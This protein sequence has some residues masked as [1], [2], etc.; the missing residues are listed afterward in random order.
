LIGEVIPVRVSIQ[1]AK[2]DIASINNCA[3]EVTETQHSE[4]DENLLGDA[5]SAHQT[6]TLYQKISISHS[7]SDR[8]IAKKYKFARDALRNDSF[9]DV[10]NL[11]AGQNWKPGL[12]K[13]ID[14]ADVFQLFRSKNSASSEYCRVWI[15]LCS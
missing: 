8:K 4:V 9:V 11:R 6:S 3:N 10:D 2:I 12:A 7:R 15:D 14:D 5:K 1:V 13:G